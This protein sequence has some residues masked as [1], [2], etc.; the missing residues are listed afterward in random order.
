MT[1][2]GRQAEEE[3]RRLR[4]HLDFSD[5]FWLGFLFTGSPRVAEVFFSRT[6]G[7]LRQRA[8][9]AHRLTPASPEELAAVLPKLFDDESA[10]AGCVWLEALQTDAQGETEGPWIRA[11][12]RLLLR[13]N[14]RR[15]RLGRT[16]AGSLILVAPPTVKIRSR[17]AAPDLWSIRA[18]VL[19]PESAPKWRGDDA[20][21]RE[22]VSEARTT[23]PEVPRPRDR[24]DLRDEPLPVPPAAVALRKARNL[25]AHGRPEEAVSAAV[26]A[27]EHF[28]QE[29]VEGPFD[30]ADA[31]WTLAQARLAE[32]DPAAA[33]EAVDEALRIRQEPLWLDL[34][35]RLAIRQ[36]DLTKAT[37][38]YRQLE[39]HNRAALARQPK[40]EERLRD[41]SVSLERKGDVQRHRARSRRRCR[42][43]RSLWVCP[44]VCWRSMGR[45]RSG[46]GTCR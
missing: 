1:V 28:R 37:D 23:L 9:R 27:I 46:C 26:R 40:S 33:R 14:E 21:E 36:Q 32:G 13:L 22:P 10:R 4:R 18:L 43:T 3:W 45:A 31:Y 19:E 2:L 12:D 44:V 17:E 24:V 11:W 8:L 39:S 7:V 30:L 35:G 6:E 42:R 25:L 29:P 34:A 20:V 5:G 15:E 38:V 16:L 41:L